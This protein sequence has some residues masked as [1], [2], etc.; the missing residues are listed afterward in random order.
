M[1]DIRTIIFRIV[2]TYRINA[3]ND[4]YHDEYKTNDEDMVV[5][6]YGFKIFNYRYSKLSCSMIHH[7]YTNINI[8][9]PKNY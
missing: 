1:N 3:L 4:E 8:Y 5:D 2:I 6:N 9:L 7:F